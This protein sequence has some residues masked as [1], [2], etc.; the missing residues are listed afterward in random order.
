MT[1]LAEL[2]GLCPDR[3]LSPYEA[4]LVAER[5]AARLL[6]LQQISEPPVPEQLIE[7]FPRVQVRYVQASHLSGS[8]RFK[9]GR[10]QILINRDATWGRIRF[11]LAHEFK[12]LLDHPL[13]STIYGAR[14]SD[15][16]QHAAERSAEVFAAALLMPK[17]WMKRV[18]YDEGLRD[19]RALRRR[20]QVSAQALRIRLDELGLTDP[21]GATA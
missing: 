20:F 5:Q 7:Y 12:H 9:D 8:V 6:R 2:R 16:A 17:A 11:T 1:M 15:R 13:A 10:W 21:V 19:E 18:Y 3:L 4:R 14:H